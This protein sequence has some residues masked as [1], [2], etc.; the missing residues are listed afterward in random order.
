MGLSLKII[1]IL[2][3]VVVQLV[4]RDQWVDSVKLLLYWLSIPFRSQFKVLVM[5]FKATFLLYSYMFSMIIRQGLPSILLP[6]EANR[7]AGRPGPFMLWHY[8]CGTN[9]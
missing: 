7:M 3:N 5:T 8:V 2:Q 1:Q 9:Y 4:S 6:S